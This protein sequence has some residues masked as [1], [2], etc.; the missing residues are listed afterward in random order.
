MKKVL[1]SIFID[2][3][4]RMAINHSWGQSPAPVNFCQALVHWEKKMLL[5]N[6]Y[7]IS[8]KSM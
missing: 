7:S 4:I 3:L 2:K 8:A 1:T 5:M 6:L